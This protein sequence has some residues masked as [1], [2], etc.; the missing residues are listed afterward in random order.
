MNQHY[1]VVTIFFWV[2]IML[3]AQPFTLKS[4]WCHEQKCE[5]F[6][7]KILLNKDIH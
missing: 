5:I 1:G 3:S 6:P 7:E 2:L 4:Y